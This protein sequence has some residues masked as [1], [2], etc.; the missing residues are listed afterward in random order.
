MGGETEFI[1]KK[2]TILRLISEK[3]PVIPA[4][5]YKEIGENVLM[6]SAL[7][8]EM[9][10]EKS[11][12]ISSIKIGG[13]P[14]YYFEGQEHLLEKYIEKLHEKEQK[15]IELLKQKKVLMDRLLDPVVRVSLRQL[16]DFAKAFEVKIGENK[17]V[18]WKWHSFPSN[19][20]E[21][22]VKEIWRSTKTPTKT[23][24]NLQPQP[25]QF[26]QDKDNNNKLKTPLK[27]QIKKI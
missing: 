14:L 10:S 21:P 20:L 3:G 4:Q 5:V 6:A 27:Q 16:K 2:K 13:S 19:E 23:I 12:K 25:S 9:A 8:S 17:E 22:K 26:N 24:K 18:F 1:L 7:L 11:I 15:S